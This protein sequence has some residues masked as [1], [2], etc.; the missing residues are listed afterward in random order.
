MP[1]ILTEVTR[2]RFLAIV[3]VVAILILNLP[4]SNLQVGSLWQG[5]F[6]M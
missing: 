4:V 3:A 2:I 6:F 1:K 5:F